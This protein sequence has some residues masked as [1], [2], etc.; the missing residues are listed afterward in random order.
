MHENGAVPPRASSIE[1]APMRRPLLAL[2]LP[3]AC[4]NPAPPQAAPA[5]APE[6]PARPAPPPT[7]T[8]PTPPPPPELPPITDAMLEAPWFGVDADRAPPI[9]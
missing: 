4:Q 9:A 3:L 1:S 8:P 5:A 6:A 7:P 2:L